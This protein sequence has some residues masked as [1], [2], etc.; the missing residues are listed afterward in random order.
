MPQVFAVALSLIFLF[1]FSP[2][3]LSAQ[4]VPS[5]QFADDSL[6]Y[7][8]A[9]H[10]DPLLPQPLTSLV[11]LYEG[12]D[13]GDELIGLYRSHVEKYPD[14]A[15]AK[16]V[17]IRIL[18]K[19]RR[20]GVGEQISTAVLSHPDFPPLQYLLY[21]FLRAKGDV[22]A[23]EALS[24]AINLETKVARKREW[25]EELLQLSEGVEAR[26]QARAQ[27]QKLLDAEGQT[28]P[29]LLALAKLMQ[30]YEFWGLSEKALIAIPLGALDPESGVEKEVLRSKAGMQLGNLKSAAAI[31]D[32]VLAKLSPDH[33]RRREVMS[34]R[35]SVVASDEERGK[36]LGQYKTTFE[37]NPKNVAALLDYIDLLVASDL[38]TQAKEL[39]LKQAAELPQS[40]LVEDRSLSLLESLQDPAAMEQFLN[41]RLELD[42]ERSDLRFRLV[43]ALYALK[44]DGDAEQEFGAVIAGLGEK[45]VSDRILELQRYLRS[46][47][48]IEAAGIYLKRYVQANP[49]RL[50]VARE[51]AEIFLALENDIEVEELISVLS[52]AEAAKE[53][54]VDFSEFLIANGFLA[55]AKSILS[56]KLSEGGEDFDLGLLLIE[57]LGDT[58][59]SANSDRLVS[60]MRELADSPERYFRW[61][62]VAVASN[63]KLES[64]DRFFETER[65]RFS[66][67]DGEWPAEKVE[68]FVMLCEVGKKR[69][70]AGQ[71]TQA[72]REQL[73]KGNFDSDLRIR[74]RN[75]LVGVLQSDPE[76]SQE[77]EEQLELLS[78]EDPAHQV[79]YDLQRALV[80]H[81]NQRVDLAQELLLGVD[82]AGVDEV[83]L[84]QEAAEVLISYGYLE[85]AERA[86]TAVNRLAP[87]DLFSWEKRLTILAV[88]KRET[89]FRLL[90][91]QLRSGELGYE[92]RPESLS[93]L[94]RHII[95][96]YWRSVSRLFASGQAQRFEEILPLL[97]SVDRDSKVP[98]DAAWTEWSRAMVLQALGR[99]SEVG[100]GVQ[101]L[102][103][104][105]DDL[106]LEEIAF[107]D[108]IL[109]SRKG[110]RQFLARNMAVEPA[111]DG[112]SGDFLFSSPAIRWAFEIDRGIR[113]ERFAASGERILILDERGGVYG[114]N[115]ANGK[116]VWSK[117]VYDALPHQLGSSLKTGRP[118][119]FI[120]LP[121]SSISEIAEQKEAPQVKLARQWV[122]DESQ[123]AFLSGNSL[124]ALQSVDGQLLW[125]AELPFM[126]SS[127]ASSSPR[128]RSGIRMSR[129]RDRVFLFQPETGQ[130]VAVSWT[131]GKLLWEVEVGGQLQGNISNLYSLN[132][133][134]ASHGG[135]VFAYGTESAVLDGETGRPLWR[136]ADQIPL[137]FP[138][139]LR[140][141]RTSEE[142]IE[143][144]IE[145]V[146]TDADSDGEN[147]QNGD[148][149]ALSSVQPRVFDFLRNEGKA[150]EWGNFSQQPSALVSPAAFW[151]AAR[152]VGN[153]SSMGGLSDGYLWLMQDETVRRI[154]I[155]FPVTSR[156]LPA[157]GIFLGHQGNHA[158]FLK[159]RE[160]IHLDFYHHTRSRIDLE[161]MGPEPLRAAFSGNQIIVRGENGIRG[162]NSRTGTAIGSAVLPERLIKYLAEEDLNNTDETIKYFWQ[163]SAR[164]S[165]IGDP[166]YCVPQ[167]D[168]L[169]NG[170]YVTQFG[171]N[172]LVCLEK[173]SLQ[174]S[175][176]GSA[177]S[178]S[179]D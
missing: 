134:I 102:E 33:W 155:R 78:E 81:R 19:L 73:A 98:S 92:F 115:S 8:T 99:T 162:I 22:R 172:I 91:R 43:R 11:K 149:N 128:S 17:L 113:I 1:D 173:E 18:Q 129:D 88:L 14:D 84:V 49:E 58:G 23:I 159:G 118:A 170:F 176:G 27:L 64:L 93:E 103:K 168:L 139:V 132:S 94:D 175:T 75:F 16:T 9:L 117:S 45:E 157:S 44:R 72:V 63:E 156:T 164:I 101:R 70:M 135:L 141:Q 179:E 38:Q 107:P 152:F 124:R 50:S 100:A 151:S 108:G 2:T 125:S 122:T 15:G 158:W 114:I 163:G 55:Q 61:L 67:S 110:A 174:S 111:P 150:R 131:S 178:T 167:Q 41:E 31:L 87:A 138:V 42:P 136:F 59:D 171:R 160:L 35:F 7:R 133:G 143:A 10:Y 96:S 86:L 147:W 12:A 37:E 13:R 3:F 62:E 52:V 161:P 123:V 54:V 106:K 85:E 4:E 40:A 119:A 6:Q 76:F 120:D 104:L 83:A 90:V 80:Y 36:L 66:F 48:R 105:L 140:K 20:P 25:L 116:L 68:K 154:S 24:K 5:T 79:R 137:Q 165:L 97:A 56:T 65:N 121:G 28:G 89:D 46:I 39:L 127:I 77:V 74:L 60:R 144:S 153:Q 26:E 95:A 82:L 51:L 57:V 29:G 112:E 177:E 169:E 71:V 32:A 34:L 166:T 69:Q 126:D 30:R 142:I 109:L 148:A 47:D 146:A 21:E 53:E 130:L 145:P